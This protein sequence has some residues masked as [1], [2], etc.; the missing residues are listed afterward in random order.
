MEHYEIAGYESARSLARQLG[1]RDAAQLLEQTLKEEV[2]ADKQ[3]AQISKRLL[4][5]SSSRRGEEGGQS[6]QDGRRTEPRSTSRRGGA[7]RAASGRARSRAATSRNPRGPQRNA[8]GSAHPLINHEE[9]RRWAGERGATPACVKGT[10]SRG[11]IGM[12]RLDF[13][14]YTGEESLQPISWDDWF[15][16]FDE[17]GLTLMVQDTTAN[18]QKSNFNKLVKRETVEERPKVRAA[19]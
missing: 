5:E 16:K 3:L 6:V 8:G 7:G 13:P 19:R 10:G 12:I 15:R 4:K 2:E 18:G 17:R 11:D 14:G 1:M 9:I